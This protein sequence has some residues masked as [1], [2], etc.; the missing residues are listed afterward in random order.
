MVQIDRDKLD[1]DVYKKQHK[2]QDENEP[3]QCHSPLKSTG[4]RLVTFYHCFRSPIEFGLYR[5]RRPTAGFPC[6]QS[7]LSPIRSN[8]TQPRLQSQCIQMREAR[9][10]RFSSGTKPQL[11]ESCDMS[12]L[13]PM[14][15]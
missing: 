8:T 11:R 6:F 5:Q 10:T 14:T 4:S 3:D 13:S 7:I 15:K 1:T 2:D 9:P 12:R